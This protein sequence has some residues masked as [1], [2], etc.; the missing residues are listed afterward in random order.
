MAV[1]TGRDTACGGCSLDFN[2]SAAPGLSNLLRK[3]SINTKT[4]FMAA[5]TLISSLANSQVL[6]VM[7]QLLSQWFWLTIPIV[8]L[9]MTLV[10]T[11]RYR[12][13]LYLPNKFNLLSRESYRKMSI[14]EAQSILK[15]LTELE[16]P[17]IFGFAIIFALFKACNNISSTN[18]LSQKHV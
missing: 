10:S 18:L 3:S 1:P 2:S 7:Q 6:D 12:R 5:L 8:L 9:Y 11:L 14:D 16:F 4:G 15:D 13:A 17:K